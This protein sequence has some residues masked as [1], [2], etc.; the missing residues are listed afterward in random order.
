MPLALDPDERIELILASDRDKTGDKKFCF[1]F[2]HLPARKFRELQKLFNAAFAAADA[3]KW[4][5]EDQATHDALL[6]GLKEITPASTPAMT[7]SQTIEMLTIDERWELLIE[8]RKA[9][10]LGGPEK[11]ASPSPLPSVTESSAAVAA[12]APA[13]ANPPSPSPSSSQ[14]ESA[15]SATASDASTAPTVEAGAKTS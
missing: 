2:S 13:T 9:L 7:I 11:K 8:Y 14:T 3:E 6:L 4:D 1:I 5:D 15:P 12:T 10:T